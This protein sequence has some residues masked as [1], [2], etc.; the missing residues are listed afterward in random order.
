MKE[1]YFLMICFSLS[2]FAQNNKVND[3]I[4]EGDPIYWKIKSSRTFTDDDL[5]T[6]LK[7]DPEQESNIIYGSSSTVS[8][9][10]A[11][12]YEDYMLGVNLSEGTSKNYY[13]MGFQP[14]AGGYQYGEGVERIITAE[15]YDVGK[16]NSSAFSFLI[17]YNFS[18]PVL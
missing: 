6:I 14:A 18:I 4:D 9:K 11:S 17:G 5:K 1:I 7:S 13:S 8:T 12:L 2:L 15:E 10:A 16:T 3:S